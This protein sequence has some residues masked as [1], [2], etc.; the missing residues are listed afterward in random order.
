VTATDSL[1]ANVTFVSATGGGVLNGS[2]VAWSNALSLAA[3]AATN[4]TLTVTAPLRGIVTN[5][6]RAAGTAFDPNTAN[7][8]SA[9]VITA[10]SNVLPVANAD[11]CTL[12]KN[13]T[14]N[15]P[16]SGV[17]ANDTD[18]NGDSLSALKLTNPSHGTVTV[19]ANGG[20]TYTPAT[21]YFGPDSFTYQAYDSCMTSLAATVSLTITNINRAP[22]ANA[23]AYT[24]GKNTT[25]NVPAAGVLANDTDADGD[26]LTA[27]KVT[28]PAHGTVTL[29]ANGGFSYT[30]T[31]NYYGSDSF[32]YLANDGLT[33]ST[34]ATVSL[35]ITNINRAPV[36]D[37]Q[38]LST[39]AQTPLAIT[40][41]GSDADNDPLTFAIAASPA[42]GTLTNFNA[43]TGAVTYTPNAGYS[44]ADSCT[45]LA[46]DGLTNSAAATINLIVTPLADVATT[47]SGSTVVFA[48][49]TFSYTVTVTNLG[50][51]AASNVS[52]SDVLPDTITFVSASGGVT[53][54]AGVITWPT[55]STLAGG[56]ATNFTVTVSTPDSGSL[57]NFAG[58][59]AT[60]AD[61]VGA[62][63][64][65]TAPAAQVIS[66]VSGRPTLT[67][68]RLVNGTVE[69]EVFTA[70]NSTFWIHASTNLVQ[71]Q[72][73]ITTNTATGHFFYI[74]TDAVNYLRRFYRSVHPQ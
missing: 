38:S 60:T 8:L 50:P 36:A 20:F 51:T 33:N 3:G 71:W 48:N 10:V 66:I 56:A 28:D 21:N 19:N 39:P 61:P 63:N 30:P 29:N 6:A 54:L 72:S 68:R 11:A 57:T 74:D 69:L 2:Q 58:S 22:V 42:N 40:L 49:S 31:N 73:L 4:F 64:D 47:V 37:N 59:T 62:N 5:T 67:A 13:T 46:N 27:V 1:P 43:A 26:S 55:L 65:G 14:M 16:A 12:G 7:N 52:V 15:V 45:F 9:P 32:T 24:L 17:L 70:S 18:A 35:T 25:L 23:D 34:T 41:T 44:G 53:P